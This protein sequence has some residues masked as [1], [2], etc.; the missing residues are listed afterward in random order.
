MPATAK[1][2]AKAEMIVLARNAAVAGIPAK[3]R[4]QQKKES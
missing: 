1:T 4:C 3:T 2:P